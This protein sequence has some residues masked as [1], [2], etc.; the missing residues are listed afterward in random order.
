MKTNTKKSMETITS[1]HSRILDKIQS[2]AIRQKPRWHFVLL[3]LLF[4][5]G[6]IALSLILLYLVGF[7]GLVFR[8]HLVFEALD[9]GPRTFFAMMH[10]LPLLLIVIVITVF[11][12][13]HVLVR[14]FAFAYMKPVAVTLGGGLALTLLLFA[15]I[16]DAD[17]DM[18]IAHLGEGHHIFGIDLLHENF[19]E[20]MPPH[21]IHASVVRKEDDGYR[22]IN[23][24]TGHELFVHV[25]A[26]TTVDREMYTASDT[27]DLLVEGHGD[28][29]YAIGIRTP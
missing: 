24:M 25:S 13:L 28:D 16:L 26:T 9:F 29:I 5:F 15:G 27:V 23:L 4:V 12:L 19:R 10:T 7:V 20:K 18:R 3:A 2:G 11:L 1:I 17:K 21:L 6:V 14:H 22:I 8:E